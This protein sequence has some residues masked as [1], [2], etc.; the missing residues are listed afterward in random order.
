VMRPRLEA[1]KMLAPGLPKLRKK[2][3]EECGFHEADRESECTTL[4]RNAAA[5]IIRALG[6]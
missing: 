4:S 1:T 5:E 6:S 3:V 2:S